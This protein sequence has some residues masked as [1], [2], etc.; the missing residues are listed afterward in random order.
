[1]FGLSEPV[2]DHEYR[3]VL[4]FFRN[5]ESRT[6]SIQEAISRTKQQIEQLRTSRQE[7]EKELEIARTHLAVEHTASYQDKVQL[8]Q[9]NIRHNE[10]HI[11]EQS[12]ILEKSERDLQSCVGRRD[13]QVKMA[14]RYLK[15][16]VIVDGG[17]SLQRIEKDPFS[18][19]LE[20][21]F[22]RRSVGIDAATYRKA[23][24]ATNTESMDV[25][26]VFHQEVI[27]SSQDQ[28]FDGDW[29]EIEACRF[30]MHSARLFDPDSMAVR[31]GQSLYRAMMAPFYARKE[32][33][34][35]SNEYDFDG[36][37][38]IAIIPDRNVMSH[39]LFPAEELRLPPDIA[40]FNDSVVILHCM[41]ASHFG[42]ADILKKTVTVHE[43]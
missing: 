16:R 29:G 35:W 26:Y 21:L 27:S 10:Q 15:Q 40:I 14:E 41:K 8:A 33:Y 28:H 42:H 9:T 23:L 20:P 5:M 39:P 32:A 12:A 4:E 43:D 13:E 36:E 19:A 25:L 38:D 37:F 3:Q 11:K 1:M 24:A 30:E 22:D 31:V 34:A 2:K 6:R 17:E 7:Y 18:V